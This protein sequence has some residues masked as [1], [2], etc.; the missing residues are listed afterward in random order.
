MEEWI[1]WIVRASSLNDYVHQK[2][3]T[4]KISTLYQISGII[5][6]VGEIE[7]G[8]SL[9]LRK[10]YPIRILA[11]GQWLSVYVRS[12]GKDHLV[13]QDQALG[14]KPPVT[15]EYATD[16]LEMGLQTSRQVLT[17]SYRSGSF[18]FR[19]HDKEH[20]QYRDLR[21]YHL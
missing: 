17:P 20:A 16:V 14:V 18:G 15:I 21:A 13:F 10:W 12:D 5:R 9:E 19:L 6:K 4:N 7:H 2:L 11:R 8:L 3:G 1:G